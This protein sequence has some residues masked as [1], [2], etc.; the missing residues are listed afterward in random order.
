M[1][2]ALR[3]VESKNLQQITIHPY[4]Q[5]DEKMDHQELQ[6]FDRLLV[7]LWTSHSIRP[8]LVYTL[9][10]GRA[11]VS[12]LVPELTRR[13]LIDLVKYSPLS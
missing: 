13:G 12:G 7:Q 2:A 3:T 6:N 11:F 4:A 10:N 1:I 9:D 5:E 8:Q